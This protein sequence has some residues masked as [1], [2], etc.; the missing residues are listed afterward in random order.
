MTVLVSR[1]AIPTPP[2]YMVRLAKHF[3]HRVPVERDEKTATIRFPP[4][5][6]F[7]VA[8]DDVLEMRL[9]V[10]DEEARDR[11]Q[12][13]VTRHLKQVASAEAFDVSWSPA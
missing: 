13:V 5:P 8:H 7:L 3:E 11:L 4:G 9:D 12:E 2:R 10:A 1:V 6:C